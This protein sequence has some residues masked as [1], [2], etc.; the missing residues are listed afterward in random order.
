MPR[1]VATVVA[2]ACAM[3]CFAGFGLAGAE[4][5]KVHC[6]RAEGA[7]LVLRE[8]ILSSSI[9][10]RFPLDT[11]TGARVYERTHPS[12]EDLTTYGIELLANDG[13]VT[14]FWE[15]APSGTV[16]HREE[17][18]ALADG[19]DRFVKSGA[20][21]PFVS[22]IGNFLPTWI[23]GAG[24][25]FF[26]F[27]L[28]NARGRIVIDPEANRVTL[29]RWRWVG[30]RPWEL[31]LD[32]IQRTR[33]HPLNDEDSPRW[34]IVFQMSGGDAVLLSL[35]HARHPKRFALEVDRAI[36][37][38]KSSVHSAHPDVDVEARELPS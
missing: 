19:I 12:R 35:S 11:L 1:S 10:R 34:G 8:G 36:A 32:E 2:F 33:L 14:L 38:A 16:T 26:A 3:V 7:C 5:T 25:V 37:Q 31:P 27:I 6:S 13:P 4:R 18:I 9:E 24:V 21:E 15:D 17:D 20:P 22:I 28:L 30:T 23:T 29:Q